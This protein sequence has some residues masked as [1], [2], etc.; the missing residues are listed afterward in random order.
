[1]RRGF[2]RI[3]AVAE[4]IV[5]CDGDAELTLKLMGAQHLGYG[6]GE[7]HGNVFAGFK[8]DAHLAVRALPALAGA[9]DVPTAAH[10]HVRGQRGAARE[11]D[12][13]PLAA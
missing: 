13:Q 9:I 11:M 1:M 10:E 4:H 2:I 5:G 12:E 8:H 7:A 6:H 3:E